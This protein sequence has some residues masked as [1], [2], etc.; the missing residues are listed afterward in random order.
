MTQPMTE[1][2]VRDELAELLRARGGGDE[3]RQLRRP[4]QAPAGGEVRAARGVGDADTRTTSASWRTR[5]PGCRSE[6]EAEDEEA[7]RFDLLMLHLQL[8][9][10]RVEP[11]FE[12]LRDQ[13]T[14]IAG[15]AGGE[16]EHPDGA[17]ADAA[18]PGAA[19]RRVVAGRD[20]ADAGERSQRLRVLVKLIEKA[21]AQAR[22]H[23]LR[24]PDGRR[25][26]SGAAGLRRR[27]RL[28]AVPRQGAAVP[29]RST[30][31]TSRSTSCASN[32]PLT[33]A[34]L[35]ELERM[36][37]ESGVGTSSRS[38]PRQTRG[39]GASACSS[40]RWSAWTARRRRRRWPDSC[41]ARRRRRTRSS[42]ST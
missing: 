42:S 7:K 33:P 16:G 24:G 14:A 34:D 6:L 35:A 38:Q 23:R 2:H 13:V 31:I 26:A 8:A 41:P 12:R 27:C 37:V 36:L 15:I 10:L 19:D 1:E 4:P 32:K 9:L 17:R 18:D 3:P 21:E 29:A 30:R 39:A 20:H 40:A 28:R 25:D 11:G 5:S 22:L